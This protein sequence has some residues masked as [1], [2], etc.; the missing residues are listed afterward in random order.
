[1]RRGDARVKLDV[2]Y[3]QPHYLENEKRILNSPHEV[4]TLGELVEQK[5][6]LKD[7][8]GGWLIKKK[9]YTKD[10]IPIIRALNVSEHG[11]SCD[12][13]VYISEQKHSDLVATEILPNDLLLTMRGSIGRAAIVPTTIRTAN[14]NAA[15]CRIRLRDKSMNAFVRDVLNTAPGLKQS[16]RHGHKAV[17]GDLTLGAIR[18]FFI[19]LPDR[20]IRQKLVNQLDYA[21]RERAKKLDKANRLLNTIDS[22]FLQT[23]GIIS[24]AQNSRNSYAIPLDSSGGVKRLGA[25]FYHP[26]R[27]IA[28][29]AIQS[30]SKSE[31]IVKLADI[32]D[33]MRESEKSAAAQEY[34]GLADVESNTGELSASARLAPKSQCFVFRNGD[35][36]YA[37]LRPYLN[38]VWSADRR[39]VCSTEFHVLR[40]KPSDPPI[41][42]DYLAA[43]LRS[44]LVVAQTKHMMT[45]NTHPRLANDDVADL[46]VPIPEPTT[47]RSIVQDIRRRRDEAR[48]LRHE[49]D[50]EWE[51]AKARFEADLLGDG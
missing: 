48:K 3:W 25:N 22:D 13:F 40:I 21:R 46:L 4:K 9:E 18:G 26:E 14:M 10:G 1:M 2:S 6:G 36:L 24:P 20:L 35:V 23:L 32:V 44:S 12:D 39:G 30:A 41:H 7:G 15:I 29:R 47:Q 27:I 38:K 51:G 28:L 42:S 5:S 33:F 11:L 19:P 45:G 43:A 8:P 17:Q 50:K 49:A 34:I 37:R 31:S 16:L